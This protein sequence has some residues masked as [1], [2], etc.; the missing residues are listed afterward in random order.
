[1]FHLYRALLFHILLNLSVPPGDLQ[2][3]NSPWRN[4]NEPQ[5]VRQD[6]KFPGGYE[7]YEL[8]A[9]RHAVRIVASGCDGG[10]GAIS[11][12]RRSRGAFPTYSLGNQYPSTATLLLLQRRT[13]RLL[14]K[15]PTRVA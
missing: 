9:R 4:K 15:L 11:I 1:M 6:K 14:E 8:E 2:N 7:T 3:R 13:H 10:R 5:K 12:S